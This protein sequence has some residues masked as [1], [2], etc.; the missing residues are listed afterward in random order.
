[1]IMTAVCMGSDVHV[2]CRNY[3]F[4]AIVLNFGM[5]HDTTVNN[6]HVLE[7]EPHLGMCVTYKINTIYRIGLPGLKMTTVVTLER[8]SSGQ[9]IL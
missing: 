3:L 5:H 1:M 8:V 7:C 2:H 9:C 6:L 4:L